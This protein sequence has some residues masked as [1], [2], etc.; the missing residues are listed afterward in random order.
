MIQLYNVII[1]NFIYINFILKD[2]KNSR[3]NKNHTREQKFT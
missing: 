1:I 2:E 3:L